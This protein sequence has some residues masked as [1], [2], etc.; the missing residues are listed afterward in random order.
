MNQL[1]IP[2]ATSRPVATLSLGY[3]DLAP[4][5]KEMAFFDFYFACRSR[6]TLQKAWL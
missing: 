6:I 5:T 3:L 2:L 4:A 1:A